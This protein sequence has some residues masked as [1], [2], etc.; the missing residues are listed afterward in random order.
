[1]TVISTNSGNNHSSKLDAKSTF[2]ELFPLQLY[3]NRD[4]TQA[5]QSQDGKENKS[6]GG[7]AYDVT[8]EV[9]IGR[10]AESEAYDRMPIDV[11]GK[12]VLSK[13]GWQEGK[14]IGRTNMA[15]GSSA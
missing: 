1:M 15:Q 2:S 5:P 8:A 11:F 4:F 3:M 10:D 9:F 7:M 12:S 14:A 6:S 13:L